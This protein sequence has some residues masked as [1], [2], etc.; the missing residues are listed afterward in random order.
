MFFPFLEIMSVSKITRYLVKK[1]QSKDKITHKQIN[2][3][4]KSVKLKQNYLRQSDQ[5]GTFLFKSV[6]ELLTESNRL[7][8]SIARAAPSSCWDHEFLFQN[9]LLSF[10]KIL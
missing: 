5:Q 4:R 8:A 9:F 10:G 2:L 7:I 3:I 6:T 1:N